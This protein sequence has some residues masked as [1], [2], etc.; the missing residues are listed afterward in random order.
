VDNSS[1]NNNSNCDGSLTV[2][3]QY[4]YP[5]YLFSIN[6][7][8]TY[9][10]SNIFNNLCSGAYNVIVRDSSNATQSS[11][12]TVGFDEQPVT[13]QLSLSA[14]TSATQTVS[15]NNY[16]S[17]TTYLQVVSTPPLPPGVTITFNMT[18]SSIKTYNGPGTGT[19][20]DTFEITE[21]GVLKTPTT[22]Q[23]TSTTGD[24]PNCNPETYTAVTEADTYQLTIGAN[25]PV[26]ITD[27]SILSVTNGATGAQSNCLTNLSQEIFAQF[28]QSSING[29]LCCNV[30]ADLRL[31]SINSN[32]T[33]Y[34]P[35]ANDVTKPLTANSRVLCRFNGDG[36]VFISS[37]SGGS[38]QYQ[39]TDTYYGSCE[40]ALLG[41]FSSIPGT[42]KS[43]ISVPGGTAYFGLRDAN[44]PTNSTC[45][46]VEVDCVDTQF[47][48]EI[49]Q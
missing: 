14:N 33:T 46:T 12:A 10:S 19:I 8:N 34:V 9:Q 22:T 25:S 26:L 48:D 17:R 44:N 16:N 39:M 30:V 31:N 35:G 18:I 15:L 11:S 24:R 37:I 4:G 45:L 21:N 2:N 5:P 28:T 20:T 32:T 42:S 1:C 13:Y 36:T 27:T 38:G 49:P 29:C 3:A 23:S 6:N 40:D 41:T 43:Y 7:G 47:R